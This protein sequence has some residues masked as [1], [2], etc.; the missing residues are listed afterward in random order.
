MNDV[1]LLLNPIPLLSGIEVLFAALD[2]PLR[3]LEQERKFY[4]GIIAEPNNGGNGTLLGGIG[5]SCSVVFSKFSIILPSSSRD[6][7]H[8][9]FLEL[10]FEKVTLALDSQKELERIDL[11]V[12]SLRTYICRIVG[13]NDDGGKIGVYRQPL[14]H[15]LSLSELH[16]EYLAGE[17]SNENEYLRLLSSKSCKVCYTGVQVHLDI[18]MV[19]FFSSPSINTLALAITEVRNF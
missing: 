14:K 5:F 3:N 7:S 4:P 13:T 18:G 6:Y 1:G 16:I 12:H 17:L 11:S 2:L 19:I 9:G 10:N 8:L 15:A